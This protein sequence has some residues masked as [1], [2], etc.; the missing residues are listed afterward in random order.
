M[1]ALRRVESRPL[2]LRARSGR[3]PPS[4]PGQTSRKFHEVLAMTFVIR[5]GWIT[6]RFASSEP[7]RCP[8]RPPRRSVHDGLIRFR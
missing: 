3:P 5:V 1:F 6:R 4:R 2:A 8:V 7:T